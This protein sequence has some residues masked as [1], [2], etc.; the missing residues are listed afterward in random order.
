M[1]LL[2]QQLYYYESE[3]K[4]CSLAFLPHFSVEQ[5]KAFKLWYAH[6]RKILNYEV[7]QQ[8]WIKVDIE[9][10]AKKI[11][12]LPNGKAQQ[13]T[14]F[15]GGMLEGAWNVQEGV[16]CLLHFRMLNRSLNIALLVIKKRIF[17]LELN[18]L[19]GSAMHI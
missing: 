11:R 3:H 7:H 15:A 8:T 17:I 9:G 12:L 13:M 14:L 4:L 19:M 18:I 1:T 6:R 16:C 2:H 10:Q 5:Q